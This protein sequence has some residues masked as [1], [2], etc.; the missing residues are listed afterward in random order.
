MSTFGQACKPFHPCRGMWQFLR[1]WLLRL[2]GFE[3]YAANLVCPRPCNLVPPLVPWSWGPGRTWLAPQDPGHN[4]PNPHLDPLL[5]VVRQM[6]NFLNWIYLPSNITPWACGLILIEHIYNPNSPHRL[7]AEIAWHVH[8]HTRMGKA[9]CR[10]DSGNL[11]GKT[12][13]HGQGQMQTMGGNLEGQTSLH[14]DVLIYLGVGQS[15]GQSLNCYY[16][17]YYN[18]FSVRL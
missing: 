3:S 14:A 11:E 12:F 5:D 8:C 6:H 17:C 18:Y 13:L 15:L 9:K 10:S 1:L 2:F 4:G 7:G 16:D